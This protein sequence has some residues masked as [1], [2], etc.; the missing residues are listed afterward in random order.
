M[1]DTGDQCVMT[2]WREGRRCKRLRVAGTDYCRQH[3][4]EAEPTEEDRLAVLKELAAPG[5]FSLAPFELRDRILGRPVGDGR[6]RE[7]REWLR[8]SLTLMHAHLEL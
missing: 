6:S 5:V 2:I 4:R 3:Q 7:H 8:R 1:S